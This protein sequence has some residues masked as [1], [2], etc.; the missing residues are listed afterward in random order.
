MPDPLVRSFAN[1]KTFKQTVGDLS[2][3]E[4]EKYC[5]VYLAAPVDALLADLAFYRDAW[6]RQA[7]AGETA[8]QEARTAYE[9]LLAEQQAEMG[10]LKA[11]I[12]EL[13]DE[14]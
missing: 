5:P 9:R 10:R 12:A 2:C 1:S 8:R 6:K 4:R 13:T 7:E 3:D 11:R 14:A